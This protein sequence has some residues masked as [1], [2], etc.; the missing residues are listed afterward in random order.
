MS[1]AVAT[2]AGAP[3]VGVGA[4]SLRPNILDIRFPRI[5]MEGLEDR[6]TIGARA[7]HPPVSPRYLDP[8]EKPKKERRMSL[9]PAAFMKVAALTV[10]TWPLRLPA[11]ALTYPATRRDSVVETHFGVRIADPYRWLEQLDSPATVDWV[12]VQRRL[13]GDFLARLPARDRV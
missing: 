3:A 5:L 13:T 11:Q 8:D 6:G 4:A 7:V 12:A 1:T 2:A 9:R 10:L